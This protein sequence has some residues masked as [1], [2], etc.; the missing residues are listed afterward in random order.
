MLFLI[1]Y[2]S[3]VVLINFAFSTAPHLD[4]IWSAWG[5][6]VF[7]LRDMVQTRFGH[8]AII[9]MLAALVLSYVT[10][11]PAIAWPAPRRL[12]YPSA[13]TGSCSASPNARCTIA[14]G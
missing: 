9:A 10:S 4:V 1:A 11:D 13:S 5:G 14:C 7:I 8:G 6:L 12:R 3:S 2:I